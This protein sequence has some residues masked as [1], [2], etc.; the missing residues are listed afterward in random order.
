MASTIFLLGRTQQTTWCKLSPYWWRTAAISASFLL[1]K[2]TSRG[3]FSLESNKFSQNSETTILKMSRQVSGL[4]KIRWQTQFFRKD[5]HVQTNNHVRFI[6]SGNWSKNTC[7]S[8]RAPSIYFLKLPTLQI[9]IF[10]YHLHLF[11]MAEIVFQ[12]LDWWQ[13]TFF[14]K[15]SDT[16][17]RL[18]LNFQRICW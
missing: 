4:A 2:T 13:E 1:S 8:K 10:F 18:H 6:S 15:F 12:L 9:K 5:Q 3:L 11:G 16:C 14:S 17:S 7:F